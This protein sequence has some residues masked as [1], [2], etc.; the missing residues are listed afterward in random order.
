MAE[1]YADQVGELQ[2][3]LGDL[4]N[5]KVEDYNDLAATITDKYDS[6]LKGYETKWKSVQ[7]GGEE[8]IAALLGTKGVYGAGKKVY[9]LYK[10]IGKKKDGKE[11]E[12]DDGTGSGA[13]NNPNTNTQTG[14]DA[15]QPPEDKDDDD[16]VDVDTQAGGSGGGGAVG[17][18][19]GGGDDRPSV[20]DAPT[21]PNQPE[22]FDTGTVDTDFLP[23]NQN[24]NNTSLRSGFEPDETEPLLARGGTTDEAEG[25]FRGI[26]NNF[27]KSSAER[28]G[29]IKQFFS[30]SAGDTEQVAAD[31][32][33]VATD[34]TE[35]TFATSDAVLGA[36]PIV[37]EAALAVGGLVAIGEG[38]YHLFHHPKAP[39]GPQTQAPLQ[40]PQAL[41]QKYSSALPSVDAAVDRGGG[42]SSF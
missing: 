21:Q 32:T 35:A 24:L 40:I 15:N 37:G 11:E 12:D 26:A 5:Q 7:D 36:I 28:G 30:R 14:D 27:F 4:K 41:T 20:D 19:N 16:A 22:E 34:A 2:N 13:N 8:D 10:K 23:E 9:D 25:F 29:R 3:K 18:N 31:T 33:Q 42:Y 17:Q 6:K 1:L 39:P 38:I